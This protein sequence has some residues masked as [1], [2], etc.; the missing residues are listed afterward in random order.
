MNGM[1]NKKDSK[2][3]E[4]VKEGYVESMKKVPKIQL[5]TVED[6]FKKP[7]RKPES[8]REQGELFRKV[9]ILSVSGS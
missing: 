9:S 7:F 6:L 5:P 1:P 3:T 8:K 2:T 4:A